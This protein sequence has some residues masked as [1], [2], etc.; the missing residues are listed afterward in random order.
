MEVKSIS[1]L[2]CGWL[3]FPLGNSLA[4]D[5][6]IV[7]GTSTSSEKIARLKE[8]NIKPYLIDLNDQPDF[9]DFLNSEILIINLPPRKLNNPLEQYQILSSLIDKSPVQKV[10]FI[11]STSAYD[12]SN[13]IATEDDTILLPDNYNK[14]INFERIFQKLNN[15][16]NIIR[17]AGL[18]GPQRHPGR[19][20][21]NG[22]SISDPNIPV[23]LIHLDDCISI[24]KLLLNR[25][26]W[27]EIYNACADT[28]PTKLEFYTKASEKLGFPSPQ[29]ITSNETNEGKVVSNEKLKSQLNYQFQHPDLLGLLDKNCF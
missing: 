17:F 22:K 18:I 10:I 16:V 8:N 23:N 28:H 19:F 1:I 12:N 14:T 24:I 3:G 25:N 27:N 5:G 4:N 9:L 20:F 21:A 11:S 15:K 7:K 6:W 26:Q 29:V 2:G 13:R